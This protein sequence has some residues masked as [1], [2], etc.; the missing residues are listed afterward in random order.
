MIL[1]CPSPLFSISQ[2]FPPRSAALVPIFLEHLSWTP[3]WRRRAMALLSVATAEVTAAYI[4]AR[5]EAVTRAAKVDALN[6]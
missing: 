2:A 1:S 3:H 6:S 4:P 5:V